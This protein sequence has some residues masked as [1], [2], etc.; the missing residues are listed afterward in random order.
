MMIMGFFE[1]TEPMITLVPFFS[2]SVIF[3]PEEVKTYELKLFLDRKLATSIQPCSAPE[4]FKLGITCNTDNFD[5]IK[6]L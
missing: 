5:C 3:V 6:F 2:M 4:T 1:F